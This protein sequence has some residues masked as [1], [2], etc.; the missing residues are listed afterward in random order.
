MKA[1]AGLVTGS[2]TQMRWYGG[3]EPPAV[4]PNTMRWYLRNLFEAADLNNDGVMQP[5]EVSQLL[6]LSGFGLSEAQI[7]QFVA[8]ADLNKDGLIQFDEWISAASELM[9]EMAAGYK[10]PQAP[11]PKKKPPGERTAATSC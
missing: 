11:S 8:E 1:K 4:D 6:A 10:R 2:R 9:H 3:R 5:G 7:T